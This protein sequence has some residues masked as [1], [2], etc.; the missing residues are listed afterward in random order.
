[1]DPHIFHKRVLEYQPLFPNLR[2]YLARNPHITMAMVLEDMARHPSHKHEWTF[3]NLCKV[4]PLDTLLAHGFTPAYPDMVTCDLIQPSI[5]TLR[6]TKDT[7]PWNWYMLT[8]HRDIRIEDI[9]RHPDLPWYYDVICYNPNLTLQHVLTYPH[10]F[11]DQHNVHN[12][13]FLLGRTATFEDIIHHPDKPWSFNALSSPNIKTVEHVKRLIEY[14]ENDRTTPGLRLCICRNPNLT[15]DDLVS[16]ERDYRDHPAYPNFK[17][18]PFSPYNPNTTLDHLQPYSPPPYCYNRLHVMVDRLPLD[19]ILEHPDIP[20]DWMD[21]ITNNKHITYE[22]I[23]KLHSTFSKY[24]QKRF[25]YIPAD[26][27]VKTLFYNCSRHMPPHDKK[28]LYEDIL[29]LVRQGGPGSPGGQD[30]ARFPYEYIL[31]SPLFLEP[32][33]EEIRQYFAKRRIVR[34]MVEALSNPHYLQCR[35]RLQRECANLQIP[36]PN[37]P[38]NPK[39]KTQKRT[40]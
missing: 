26:Y 5:D 33:H 23:S 34:H 27:H 40:N 19:F 4:I 38:K 16:L 7:I 6:K 18:L 31:R 15:F 36:T 1:M 37:T 30:Y 8:S 39:P 25:D 2:R 21:I 14:F 24:L 13:F 22:S 32:T 20:W 12:V 3:D 17:L 11:P 10:L 9:A 28:Q 29:G 35:K